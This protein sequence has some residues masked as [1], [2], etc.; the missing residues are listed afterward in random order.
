ETAIPKT[1]AEKDQRRAPSPAG[2]KPEGQAGRGKREGRAGG[3][4]KAGVGQVGGG[5]G[6]APGAGMHCEDGGAPEGRRN[7][8]GAQRRGAG[9]AKPGAQPRMGK[10][11]KER[12]GGRTE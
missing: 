5:G 9:I 3:H 2:G 6:G 7:G 12:G 4:K 1:I 11:G 8:P 10:R